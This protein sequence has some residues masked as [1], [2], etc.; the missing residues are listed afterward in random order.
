MESG[1][2][3][4]TGPFKLNGVPLRRVCQSFVQPTSTK[5]DLAGVDTAKLN[6]KYFTKDKVKMVRKSEGGFFKDSKVDEAKE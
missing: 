5:V 6:D 2:L 3:L 4:V 1:L